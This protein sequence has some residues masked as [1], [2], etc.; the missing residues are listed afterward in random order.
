MGTDQRLEFQSILAGLQHGTNVYFQ[1]P[2]NVMVLYP[3]IVYN[4][5]LNDVKYADDIAYSSKTRYQVT[6]IDPNP[7]SEIPDK[8]AALPYTRMVRHFTTEGLNH[9]IYNVYF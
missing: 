7:D 2:P 5:D 6:V 3:A 1:P 8:V 9:D 4:R